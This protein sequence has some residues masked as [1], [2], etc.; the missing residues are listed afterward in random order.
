MNDYALDLGFIAFQNW[1]AV[2]IVLIFLILYIIT[3]VI[4]ACIVLYC[5]LK[6]REFWYMPMMFI[7]MLIPFMGSLF[8]LHTMWDESE[9]MTKFVLLLTYALIVCVIGA[10]CAL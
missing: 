8:G 6:E 1:W 10:V 5:G 7:F 3:N 4:S 9:R 2:A